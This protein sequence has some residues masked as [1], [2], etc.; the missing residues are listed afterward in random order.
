MSEA[1][2]CGLGVGGEGEL[3]RL[4]LQPGRTARV[5]SVQK[6]INRHQPIEKRLDYKQTLKWVPR[7]KDAK[8]KEVADVEVKKAFTDPDSGEA[9]RQ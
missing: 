6:Y 5:P 8:G 2:F 1:I 3:L 9:N 7:H 4:Q